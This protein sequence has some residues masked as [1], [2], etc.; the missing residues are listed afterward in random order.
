MKKCKKKPFLMN[1]FVLAFII[2]CFSLSTF[3]PSLFIK[4]EKSQKK[5]WKKENYL[6]L[7]KYI[8]LFVGDY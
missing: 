4:K 1:I 2:L 3:P 8:A 5:T 7:F 6:Y